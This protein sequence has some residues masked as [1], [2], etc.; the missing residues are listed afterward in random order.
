ME[1]P[2]PLSAV[3][4][5]TILVTHGQLW[6][7]N[8]KWKTPKCYIVGH[9][10]WR[11][12]ICPAPHHLGHESYLCAVSPC[13][14]MLPVGPLMAISGIRWAVK[15]TACVQVTLLLLTIGHKAQERRCWQSGYAAEKL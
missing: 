14:R 7:K 4:L 10:E 1:V 8:T 11:D 3:S 12:E 6:S 5:F 9:S 15:I 2:T 13:S